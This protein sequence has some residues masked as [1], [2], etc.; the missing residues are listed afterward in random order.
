MTHWLKLLSHAAKQTPVNHGPS[1]LFFSSCLSY[2]CQQYVLFKDS[3]GLRFTSFWYIGDVVLWS[4]QF[5]KHLY[6]QCG[7][8]SNTAGIATA[9]IVQNLHTSSACLGY[10]PRKSNMHSSPSRS[11]YFCLSVSMCNLHNQVFHSKG[12][13]MT[14]IDVELMLIFFSTVQAVEL[15]MYY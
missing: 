7:S 6:E 9:R 4:I 3:K 10:L 13:A 2:S 8:S 11:N 5:H 1:M 12:W 15:G 14:S